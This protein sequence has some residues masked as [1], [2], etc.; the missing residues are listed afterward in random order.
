MKNIKLFLQTSMLVF[1]IILTFSRC[2]TNDTP[3]LLIASP[4]SLII[5]DTDSIRELVIT[6]NVPGKVKY[7][8][9]HK[10]DWTT[11]DLL[12][13]IIDNNLVSLNIKPQTQNLKEG[14]YRDYISIISDIGGKVDIPI[15]LSVQLL[16]KIG[17]SFKELIFDEKTSQLTFDIEN[18]GNGI[19]NWSFENIPFWLNVSRNDITGYIYPNAK[20]SVKVNC[21]RENLDIGVLKS[22]FTIKSNSFQKVV[23]LPV[24]MYVPASYKLDF[25]KDKLLIDYSQ[26]ENEIYLRNRGNTGFS[27]NSSFENNFILYPNSGYLNKGDS[28]QVKISL[29]NRTEFQTG[30]YTKPIYVYNNFNRD[31]LNVNINNFI[32]TKWILDRNIAD[33]QYCSVTNKI[34]V[35]SSNPY[36]LSVIDPE[37]KTINSLNLNYAPQC[38]SVEK[39]GNYAA[40]GHNGRISFID[41]T[42]M[43]VK[44]EYVT[45]YNIEYIIITSTNWIY[46]SY[47]TS[48]FGINTNTGITASNYTSMYSNGPLVLHPSQ[49]YIFTYANGT[50]GYIYKISIDGAKIQELYNKSNSM[51]FWISNDGSRMY[52]SSFDVLS[53]NDNPANDMV[54][55]SNF[56]DLPNQYIS[57]ISDSKNGNNVCLTTGLNPYT[58]RVY[59][60]TYLRFKKEYPLESFLVND[61]ITGSRLSQGAG[62]YVFVNSNGTKA[63]VLIKAN[64]DSGLYYEWALQNIDIN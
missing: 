36:R 45:D 57:A 11:I 15:S 35:I 53:L 2:E 12:S 39:N 1:L 48:L 34:I 5:F 49:K 51:K 20:Y 31:T 60:Y 7:S 14:I 54:Y 52:K 25:S 21:I 8:I 6:T 27:W 42:K 47:F 37:T 19:L 63:Y 17:I 28:V 55:S 33:A 61:Q 16:P 4:D 10:P 62:K 32:N 29:I 26:S 24:T 23:Q 3:I 44:N 38:L 40:V 18:N 46:Y 9:T 64:P 58:M 41:L 50:T 13:G 22:Y 56:N 59:D 43:T 30:T